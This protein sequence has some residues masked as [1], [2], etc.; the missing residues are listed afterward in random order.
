MKPRAL[1]QTALLL[2]GWF[3]SVY[4][5]PSD[6]VRLMLT[7]LENALMTGRPESYNSLV[8]TNVL[9]APA[10]AARAA[11]FAGSE[12][13]AGATRVVIQ[14]RDRQNLVGTLA[15][16]GFR[17]IVD[18]FVEYGNRARVATWQL[19]IRRVAADEWRILD[20]ERLSVVEN[21]YRLTVNP[22]NQYDARD[23]HIQAEDLDLTLVEGT[24]F[25]IS[26]DQGVTGLILMGHGEMRFSPAPETE[27]GQVRILTGKDQL[28]SRFDAAY[29]RFGAFLGHA[30]PEKLV[31][32]PVDPRDLR[33]AEQIFREES[34]KS[35][36]LDMG[37]L[38]D[39]RW[40]LLPSADDFLAE[41]RT[42][43]FS[44]LTYAR[45]DSEAEDI[46][47]FDR[48]RQRNIAVYASNSG[49]R[50]ADAFTTKTI[51]RPTT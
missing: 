27:K 21:L 38:S 30:D 50:S 33:R 41:L 4:A 28:E 39:D 19:D 45:A 15:G 16:N 32:R 40:S 9:E 11:S 48:R 1:F 17:L 22:A 44:T 18:A 14:E 34:P 35:F 47:V 49:S 12:F 24:V 6:G 43:R 51:S 37:D 8:V 23:Y 42:R 13:R 2:L 46:S 25:T 36:V 5:Q 3:T 7:S 31:A 29:L 26:T 20:Q 10:S